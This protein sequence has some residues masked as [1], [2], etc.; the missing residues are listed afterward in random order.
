MILARGKKPD[1]THVLII[2]LTT[3][4][5]SRLQNGEPVTASREKHGDVIPHG[6]EILI[7]FGP[8]ERT[9]AKAILSASA[10]PPHEVHVT[11]ADE[12]DPH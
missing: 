5:V 9:L 3:E 1:G 2:G 12:K 4:N 11:R 6:L 7:A 10:G 8:D